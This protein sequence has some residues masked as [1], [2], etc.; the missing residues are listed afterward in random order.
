MYFNGNDGTKRTRADKTTKDG[1]ILEGGD[2]ITFWQAKQDL[3][4][5]KKC[6]NF[7]SDGLYF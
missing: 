5:C 1:E 3:N 4:H 7:Q 6:Q 2:V